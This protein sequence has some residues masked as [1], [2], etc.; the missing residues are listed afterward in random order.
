MFVMLEHFTE[1]WLNLTEDV[2]CFGAPGNEFA[3]AVTQMEGFL[4]SIKLV[5]VSGHVLCDKS[6]PRYKSKWGCPRSHPVYGGTPFNVVITTGESN[7]IIY[8]TEL[9]LKDKGESLWYDIPGVDPDSPELIL[10]DSSNPHYVA[11]GQEL[12]VWLA[13]DLMKSRGKK[14]EEKICITVQGWF[15]K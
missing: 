5:H 8:P 4:Q 2:V 10:G 9:S 3:T 12:R 6:S 15:M 14:I 1:R 7:S 13:E 11:S